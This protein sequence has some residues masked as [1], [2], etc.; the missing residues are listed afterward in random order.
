[1]YAST[2]AEG[3]GAEALALSAADGRVAWRHT[4]DGETAETVAVNDDLA[5]LIQQ[6]SPVIEGL[7]PTTG[8]RRVRFE[9]TAPRTVSGPTVMTG[10]LIVAE[11]DTVYA[12]SPQ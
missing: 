2:F 3:G 11:R 9:A 1:M 5:A 10:R 8:E 4:V 6:R 12:L 7:D